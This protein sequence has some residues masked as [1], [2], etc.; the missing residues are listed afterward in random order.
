[1][2]NLS[3]ESERPR[4]LTAGEDLPGKR[5]PGLTSRR[6]GSKATEP[7]GQGQ[8]WARGGHTSYPQPFT[9]LA[10]PLVC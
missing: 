7:A 5:E 3:Q 6:A 2:R 4:G 1:M 10:C 8:G 9:H